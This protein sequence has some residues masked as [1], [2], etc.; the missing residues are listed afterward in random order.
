MF[1]IRVESVFFILLY[2]VLVSATP[3]LLVLL[4]TELTLNERK[5]DFAEKVVLNVALVT[6]ASGSAGGLL[7]E[8]GLIRERVSQPRRVMSRAEQVAEWRQELEAKV[9]ELSAQAVLTDQEVTRL[10]RELTN[11]EREGLECSTGYVL[12]RCPVRIRRQHK[13]HVFDLNS[14]A[15]WMRVK[16]GGGRMATNPL[17]RKEFVPA[18]L[19]FADD[20]ADR[21]TQARIEK[22]GLRPGE[23]A[24]FRMC[25]I[26]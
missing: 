17:N 4:N 9:Q 15:A 14:I 13:D 25:N 3:Q 11:D 24:G 8:L 19:E 1:N 16:Y 23:S 7:Y 26:L 2:F 10:N 12:M 22:L 5:N 20:I 18:D 21:L 6:L